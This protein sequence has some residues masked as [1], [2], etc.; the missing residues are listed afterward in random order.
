MQS[1]YV[2]LNLDSADIL[3]LTQLSMAT[4]KAQEEEL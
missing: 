2:I 4:V 3:Q 1:M